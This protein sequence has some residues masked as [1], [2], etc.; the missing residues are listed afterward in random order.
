MLLGTRYLIRDR[1]RKFTSMF[2]SIMKAEGIEMC[3]LPVRSP[4][5]NAYVERFIQTLKIECL[6]RF[7]ILGEKQLNYLVREF[8]DYYHRQRPHQSKDNKPLNPSCHW[9]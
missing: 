6:S 3:P 9:Q 8:V 2:D 7:I 1:D 4:N 5:L